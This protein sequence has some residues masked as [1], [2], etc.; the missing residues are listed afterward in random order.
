MSLTRIAYAVAKE[1]AVEV[2]A[3]FLTL[4]DAN[5]FAESLGDEYIVQYCVVPLDIF[6]TK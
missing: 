1:D 4:T 6:Y 5:T 3:I 2:I